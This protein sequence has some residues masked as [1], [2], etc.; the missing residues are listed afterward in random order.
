MGAVLPHHRVGQRL[1]SQ[2]GEKLAA[3]SG[4]E[5]HAPITSHARQSVV[6]S[7]VQAG[8][9]C[10]VRSYLPTLSDRRTPGAP[11]SGLAPNGRP[12]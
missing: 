11:C 12:A 3:A 2:C 6:R 7:P 5:L 10:T 8:W 1:A 4:R 9:Q